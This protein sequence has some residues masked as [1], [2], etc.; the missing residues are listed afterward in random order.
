[1]G[2]GP[3]SA[4]GKRELE[5]PLGNQE[6]RHSP[7]RGHPS[8]HTKPGFWPPHPVLSP[9]PFNPSMIF[10]PSYVPTTPSHLVCSLHLNIL[11]E[12]CRVPLTMPVTQMGRLRPGEPC[13]PPGA[14]RHMREGVTFTRAGDK[15]G[16]W[17]LPPALPVGEAYRGLH[18]CRTLWSLTGSLPGLQW[19][20]IDFGARPPLLPSPAESSLEAALHPAPDLTSRPG[21]VALRLPP[22]P[23]HPPHPHPQLKGWA[24]QGQRI[25]GPWPD[26]T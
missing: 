5:G 14:P 6:S 3:S 20:T 22:L 17:H 10:N 9:L 16:S 24:P 7:P 12:M 8:D 21:R 19:D 23:P 15:L 13:G 26:C 25:P 4:L 18:P 11:R 2:S 1:M